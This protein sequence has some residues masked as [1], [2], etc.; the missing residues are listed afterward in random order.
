MGES[1]HYEQVEVV[2]RR[3]ADRDAH[4]ARPQRG[5]GVGDIGQLE[6]IETAGRADD[7]SAHRQVTA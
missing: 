4:L 3:G 5:R 2:E 6:V 7:A 1:A